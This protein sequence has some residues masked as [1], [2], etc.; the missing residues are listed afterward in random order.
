M[1]LV[2]YVFVLLLGLV[3]GFVLQSAS[4]VVRAVDS[5]GRSSVYGGFTAYR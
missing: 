3:F 5:F 1:V 2:R 4:L